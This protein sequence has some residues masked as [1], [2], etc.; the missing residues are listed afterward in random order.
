MEEGF[1]QLGHCWQRECCMSLVCKWW[2][3]MQKWVCVHSSYLVACIVGLRWTKDRE[4]VSVQSSRSIFAINHSYVVVK[5][6]F[7]DTVWFFL[8]HPHHHSHHLSPCPQPWERKG[9]ERFNIWPR[10]W[11]WMWRHSVIDLWCSYL[12]GLLLLPVDAIEG[13]NCTTNTNTASLIY[14]KSSQSVITHLCS[15]KNETEK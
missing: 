10:Y 7:G 1:H 14:S 9:T 12:A 5:C 2:K 3:V 11:C 15:H 13:L 8:T 4:K 6:W